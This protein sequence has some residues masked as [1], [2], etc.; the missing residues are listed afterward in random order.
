MG[1][2]GAVIAGE[3]EPWVCLTLTISESRSRYQLVDVDV[4]PE[5]VTEIVK[6]VNT[7]E[8]VNDCCR[9]LRGLRMTL[10]CGLLNPSAD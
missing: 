5:R 6:V 9:I 2:E 3:V 8:V 4:L 1:G 7:G 10:S